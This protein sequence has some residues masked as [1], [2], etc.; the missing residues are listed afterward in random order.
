MAITNR[1][2]IR[3][4]LSDLETINRNDVFR[5]TK[6][7]LSVA[8]NKVPISRTFAEYVSVDEANRKSREVESSSLKPGGGMVSLGTLKPNRSL[9]L[10]SDLSSEIGRILFHNYRL[11]SKFYTTRLSSKKF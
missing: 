3:K 8:K 1:R 6:G 10:S 9:R 11:R 4:L 2:H 5:Y 7:H